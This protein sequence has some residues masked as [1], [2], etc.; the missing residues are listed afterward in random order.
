MSNDCGIRSGPETE[1][2]AIVSKLVKPFASALS[3]VKSN[4]R[5][6]LSTKVILPSGPVILE[7]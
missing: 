1:E 3:F 6:L 4:A 5:R 2:V 7:A